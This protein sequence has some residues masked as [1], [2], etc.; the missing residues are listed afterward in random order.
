MIL[1]DVHAHMDFPHFSKDLKE[2]LGR[3]KNAGM[4]AIISQGVH[5]ASN[6]KTLEL[7][8]K[9]PLIKSA[10][11]LYPLNAPN[12][13]VH[14]ED[15]DDF[16][17]HSVS[18]AETLKYIKAHAAEITAI[19]EVGIDLAHSDDEQHQIQN[20]MEILRLSNAIKKPVI[21]HSRKA[22]KLILD[23]LEDAKHERAVL[24]CFSGGKKLIKR[25]IEMKVPMTVTSNANRLQH[26]QMV[27]REVP[28]KQLLTETDAP[29]LSPVAG[30]RNEPANVRIA[31]DV[32]A[33]EKALTSAEVARNIY[34]NYQRI[35]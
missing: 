24:H 30:E 14:K 3:A 17:R 9:Y 32:I 34:M 26:F 29:Y 4:A 25:A 16:D 20:F 21:I 31:V 8:A 1:V 35:F 13:A 6:K 33:K 11:G 19:G 7:G 12:V 18:V 28:L 2:V 22:E 27:A 23:I 15:D 5:H 10:M